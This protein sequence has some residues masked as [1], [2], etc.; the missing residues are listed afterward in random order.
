MLSNDGSGN[1]SVGFTFSG[2]WGPYGLAAGD[3]DG[4]GDIDLAVA[5]RDGDWVVVL[6][7]DGNGRFEVKKLI[8]DQIG[9]ASFA[10]GDW[11][12]DGDLDLIAANFIGD[13]VDVIINAG[14]GNFVLTQRLIRPDSALWRWS[15][16]IGMAMA[17]GT[18]FL[19]T[20]TME[21]SMWLRTTAGAVSSSRKP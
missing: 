8:W 20:R 12:G 16:V 7:N 4:D 11:D 18:W 21:Q 19:P 9:P 2:L 3:W 5:N 13:W 14:G 17:T 15:M 10:A 6:T 1:F